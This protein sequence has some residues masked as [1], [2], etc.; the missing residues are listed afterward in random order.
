MFDTFARLEEAIDAL[1]AR[2]VLPDPSR[3]EALGYTLAELR[4]CATCNWIGQ[5]DWRLAWCEG[6]SLAS[7]LTRWEIN[8]K[9]QPCCHA[10][11]AALLDQTEYPWMFEDAKSGYYLVDFAG[12]WQ[13][14]EWG[15]QEDKLAKFGKLF[16]RAPEQIVME[17]AF[18]F[19]GQNEGERLLEFDFHWGMIEGEDEKRCSVGAFDEKGWAITLDEPWTTGENLV[20]CLWRKPE[21][22]KPGP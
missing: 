5:S 11:S 3:S 6:A 12:R 17:A 22:F 20:V 1:G 19:Y 4:E 18:G 15:D 10:P 7:Q 9:R 21:L 2:N 14:F 13:G 16:A 8:P